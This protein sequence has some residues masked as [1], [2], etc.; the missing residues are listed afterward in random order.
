MAK[1][2]V[3]VKERKQKDIRTITPLYSDFIVAKAALDAAKCGYGSKFINKHF[4]FIKIGRVENDK[5]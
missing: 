1:Y 4:T 5:S 3:I 2:R